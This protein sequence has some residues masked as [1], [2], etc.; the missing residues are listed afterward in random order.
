MTAEEIIAGINA[1]IINPL[2]LLLIG[3]ATT[4]FIWGIMLYVANAA[5]AVKRA[6]G[7]RKIVYGLIGLF[8]M[9]SVFGIINL[10]LNTFEV[11]TI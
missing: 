11:T 8:I 7:K 3:V 5:D 1:A 2:I 6:E 4:Y 10:V 9:M